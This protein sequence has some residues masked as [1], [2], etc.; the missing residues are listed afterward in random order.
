MRIHPTVLILC[1]VLASGCSLLV[2]NDPDDL[3]GG[4]GGADGGMDAGARDAGRP[5]EDAGRP[6][7][8]R[9]GEDAG[10]SDASERN[11]AGP[12]CERLCDDGVAC[13]VDGCRAGACTNTPDD[14]ACPGGQRCNEVMGCVPLH[15][16]SAAECD[17]GRFCNGAERCAPGE[18][19]ASPDTGCAAG[20]PPRC[21]DGVGCTVDACDEDAD[22][23][24]FEPDD[25]ACDDGVGCTADTCDPAS[26]GCRNAPDDGLCD[27]GFCRVGGRCDATDG[28]EGGTVRDCRDGD[29]CTID[30]CDEAA[31]TCVHVLRDDD[32]DGFGAEA[33]GSRPCGGEDCDD[34][35]PAIHPDADESCNGVD[36]DCDDLVD[37]GCAILPDTCETAQE[38][39]LDDSGRGRVT[40][41]FGS[42]DSDYDTR[43]DRPG[44]PGPD[45]IYYIDVTRLSDVTI[46]TIGSDADTVI[47]V[48]TECS[49][50]GFS[51]VC[52]DD[53]RPGDGTDSRVWVHRIGPAS[54]VPLRPRRLFIL[55]SGWRST[56]VDDFELHVEVHG[57]APDTCSEPIDITGGGSVWGFVTAGAGGFGPTGTCQEPAETGEREGVATFRADATDMVALTAASRA[58]VPD[59]YV[60]QA[61]CSSGV[62]LA[63]EKARG[64]G[65]G[66][67]L[68]DFPI[69][70]VDGT[71]YFVFVDGVGATTL[72]TVDY[73]LE[74]KP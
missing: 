64:V 34:D 35:D 66:E 24:A 12:D 3:G 61:P 56:T 52:D 17:D 43:C 27:L 5:G 15:C 51:W 19:G 6:D 36:D 28:C 74:F 42:F 67:S 1:G 4:G 11:D 25:G 60:R 14:E 23:C 63:C 22:R 70:V 65:G 72:G 40:G 33:F 62:E 2:D 46:D 73:Y 13:T 59:L 54:T 9:P 41:T 18:P 50:R 21:D 57:A 26:G 37:E 10:R 8:G 7:A 30:R 49:G 16:S 31:A 45:A 29:T 39:V 68:A 38:I 55:V 32:G 69:S 58:F 53:L 71:R 20:T 48:A 44:D 47:A